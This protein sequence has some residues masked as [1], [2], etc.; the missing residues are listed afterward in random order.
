MSRIEESDAHRKVSRHS[1]RCGLTPLEMA[2]P[3]C[4]I[5][6]SVSNL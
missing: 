5:S 1:F 6:I 4:E 2:E 3:E